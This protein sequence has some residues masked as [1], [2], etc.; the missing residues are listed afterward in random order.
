M[1]FLSNWTR[2]GISKNEETW[3]NI[4]LGK[5]AVS[6]VFPVGFPVKILRFGF[7]LHTESRIQR[8]LGL[9]YRAKGRQKSWYIPSFLNDLTPVKGLSA[10]SNFFDLDGTD[11]IGVLADNPV[12]RRLRFLDGGGIFRSNRRVRYRG[13]G[14]DADYVG[15]EFP[16]EYKSSGFED[17]LLGLPRSIR[18]GRSHPEVENEYGCGNRVDRPNGGG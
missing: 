11:I 9:Y 12:F 8:V 7:L 15:R 2:N 5:G 1:I 18:N 3:D 4:D 17:G 16:P 13:G 10:Q 6:R 14:P